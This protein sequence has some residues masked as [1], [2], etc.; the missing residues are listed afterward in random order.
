MPPPCCV[1]SRD[2]SIGKDPED[3]P[4]FSH[5]CRCAWG[6]QDEQR[7]RTSLS[8]ASRK[9][10]IG[11]IAPSPLSGP[12]VAG[13]S[14]RTWAWLTHAPQMAVGHRG[15]RN[16]PRG[17]NLAQCLFLCK[18]RKQT[19]FFAKNQKKNILRDMKII[20][21]SN[22]NVHKWS[23]LEQLQAWPRARHKI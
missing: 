22:F 12:R 4:A 16:A 11:P 3:P 5:V 9:Q 14:L 7:T 21:K 18:S 10:I 19:I 2:H 13:T 17:P 1:V 23:V 6:S 8:G 15:P 20:W